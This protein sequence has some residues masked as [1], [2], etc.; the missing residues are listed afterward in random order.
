[1]R[2]VSR[3]DDIRSI[4]QEYGVVEESQTIFAGRWD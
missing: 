2:E 4:R 3:I 1:M